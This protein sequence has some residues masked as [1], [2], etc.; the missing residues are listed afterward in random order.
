METL[1][2]KAELKSRKRVAKKTEIA[3]SA[4]I[5]LS[6]LGYARAG[7]RDI[8]ALSGVSLG[9]IHYYFEDKNE[10]VSYAIQLYKQ[11]FVADLDA[12]LVDGGDRDQVIGAIV[13]SLE[14]TIET[15]SETHRLWY[16]FREQAMFEEAFQKDVREIEEALVDLLSRHLKLDP[17]KGSDPLQFYI[18]VDGVFRFYTHRKLMRDTNWQPAFRRAMRNILECGFTAG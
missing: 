10:L 14:T 18:A 11:Q 7:L 4:L 5:A 16:D 6:Q 1:R 3:E 2:Q 9:V 17:E 15:K 12:A 13:R 8:A